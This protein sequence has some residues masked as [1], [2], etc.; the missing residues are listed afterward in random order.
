[1]TVV[2]RIGYV[3]ILEAAEMLVAARYAG[4]PDSTVMRLR[5]Q[6][7]NVKDGIAIDQTIAEIRNAVDEGKFR[8]WAIGGRPRRVER[9]DAPPTR[10]DPK[11]SVRCDLQT[12][13]TQAGTQAD[14]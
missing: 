8:P 12:W 7:M 9:L 13:V 3:T 11:G 4:A 5:Q 10:T 1:M 14:P 2:L 6:G